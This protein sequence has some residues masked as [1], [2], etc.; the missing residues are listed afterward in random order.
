D[1]LPEHVRELVISRVDQLSSDARQVL[2]A[3]A[4]LIED[5]RLEALQAL[6]G[7]NDEA[8]LH[9][10]IAELIRAQILEQRDETHY[11]FR[12]G[13]TQRVIYETLSR[14]ERM[15]MHRTAASYLQGLDFSIPRTRELA[16][17]LSKC[18]LLPQAIEVIVNGAQQQEQRGALESAAEL[19]A[20]ALTLFPDEKSVQLELHRLQRQIQSQVLG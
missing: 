3:A 10:A 20:F 6:T 1:M 12:H 11:D 17:H 8:R 19:Y 4:V 7:W 18:G 14:M 2:R 5:F 9:T 15:K 13:M 16:Y